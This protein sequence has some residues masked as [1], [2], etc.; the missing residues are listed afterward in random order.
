MLNFRHVLFA[1]SSI[2]TYAESS[3]PGIIDSLFEIEGAA[4]EKQRWEVVRKHFS[5]VVFFIGSAEST[6]R[7]VT[8]FMPVYHEP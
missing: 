3:F 4:D 5:V 8:K 1:Q 6:L 2:N 7:D